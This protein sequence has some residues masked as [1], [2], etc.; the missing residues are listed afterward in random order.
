MALTETVKELVTPILDSLNLILFDITYQKA[1]KRGLLRIFID[2]EGGVTLDDCQ[3][4]SQE[5]GAILEVKDAVPGGYNLEVSSPG[6]NRPMRHQGDYERY[7]GSK[8]K[9]K[10]YAPLEN[11]RNYIGFNRGVDEGILT[12]EITPEQTLRI[13]ISE[14]SRANLEVEF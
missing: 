8:L 2:K 10:L 13:P 11:R 7:E 4:V 12:L 5:V 1:G 9:I 6:I 3:R 14:I